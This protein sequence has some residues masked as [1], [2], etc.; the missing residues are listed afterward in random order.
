MPPTSPTWFEQLF[1]FAEGDYATTQRRFRSEGT[2]LHSLANGRT[3]H[4]GT[5]STPTL[6]SLRERV[7]SAPRGAL[8]VRHE[9]IHDVLGLHAAPQNRGALFQAASQFNCLEFCDSHVIPE[10]GVTDYQHDR[11]QGP[12]C[13]LATAGATVY[14]NYLVPVRG[15]PGQ[16]RDRQLDLTDELAATLGAPGE[17]WDVINGYTESD[18]PRL[19]RL[20]DALATH[21]RDALLGTLKIGLQ[22]DVGVDF[23]ARF[24]ETQTPTRVSQAFCSALSCAYSTQ[25]LALWEPLARLV[26]DA[27]YEATL[28]AALVGA[29]PDAE[30]SAGPAKVW[31]TQ[32]G[33]GA[34]GNPPEWIADAMGRAL[35]RCE[36]LALD[37]RVAH[38]GQVDA[39]FEG[40]VTLAWE[41]AAAR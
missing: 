12:A 31:L 40:L 9:A 17:F 18:A 23:Q 15:I 1:G 11:T 32:L 8:Q 16:T 22:H 2:T 10:E 7:A 19:R 24:E 41:R 25:P 28:L 6:A 5:F 27:A 3:F 29:E 13:A 14:R 38:R 34:F 30:H 37:V 21:G 35:A 39:S 26:L 33:G 4:I 36:G 20:H